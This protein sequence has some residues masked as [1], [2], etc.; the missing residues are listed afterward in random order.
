MT[1]KILVLNGVNLDLL[2]TREPEIY[3][4]ASLQDLETLIRNNAPAIAAVKGLSGCHLEFIQT[5]SEQEFLQALDR[6]ADGLIVNPAAW[7]HTSV[8]IGDRLAALPV[9]FVEVHLSNI[10]AREPMREV[11]YGA[12]HASGVV[13]GFGFD[14]YLAALLGLLGRIAQS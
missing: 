11:S 14:S 12:K 9:P 8:A 7:T 4:T 13:F 5:N 10:K 2:G 1:P 3:G 6:K